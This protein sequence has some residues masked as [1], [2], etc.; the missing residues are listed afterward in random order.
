MNNDCK[1]FLNHFL[2]DEFHK[3]NGLPSCTIGFVKNKYGSPVSIKE[4]QLGISSAN[5]HTLH[6]NNQEIGIYERNNNFLIVSK[7][8]EFEMKFLSD[9]GEPCEIL[10]QQID[11][12]NHYAHEYLFCEKGLLI[13]VLE[14]LNKQLEKTISRIRAIQAISDPKNLSPE[15]YLSLDNQINW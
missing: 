13:T 9:F 14:P 1:Q 6:I 5:K 10:P 8:V 7:R 15:L 12:Q 11:V 2:H 4:T 3:L